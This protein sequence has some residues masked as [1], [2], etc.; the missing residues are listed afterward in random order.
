MLTKNA[1][2]GHGLKKITNKELLE[3]LLFLTENS[4][5]STKQEYKEERK[6]QKFPEE[7]F[8]E[9]RQDKKGNRWGKISLQ[10]FLNFIWKDKYS[11]SHEFSY[12]NR[13][14]RILHIE[15]PYTDMMDS[16][17]YFKGKNFLAWCESLYEKFWTNPN[18]ISSKL[19]FKRKIGYLEGSYSNSNKVRVYKEHKGILHIKLNK[20]EKQLHKSTQ[21]SHL[22]NITPHPIEVMPSF[23]DKIIR[24]PKAFLKNLSS[25]ISIEEHIKKQK[26]LKE[27]IDI[28]LKIVKEDKN[29]YILDEKARKNFSINLPRGHCRAAVVA[30]ELFFSKVKI[31]RH[32]NQPRIS[33][34]RD[35]FSNTNNYSTYN[36]RGI[37]IIDNNGNRTKIEYPFCMVTRLEIAQAYYPNMHYSDLSK[38]QKDKALSHFKEVTKKEYYCTSGKFIYKT[39]LY[40]LDNIV[41]NDT[42][43]YQLSPAPLFFEG[44]LEHGNFQ[45][46]ELNIIGKIENS[47]KKVLNKKRIGHTLSNLSLT[48]LCFVLIN[49]NHP[50]WINGEWHRLSL[51]SMK[52]NGW[53]QD[54]LVKNR[55][56]SKIIEMLENIFKALKSIGYIERY[57]FQK[58]NYKGLNGTFFWVN[59]P[60]LKKTGVAQSLPTEI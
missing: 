45:L 60:L 23:Q 42:K 28:K 25:V 55:K 12:L 5:T 20:K 59:Q 49:R 8:K 46:V 29:R 18:K 11:Q 33:E 41:N 24:Y 51:Q 16:N 36:L 9:I 43:V 2:N 40:Y 31:D 37:G 32:I 26:I 6:T 38:T 50:L 1:T 58:S 54:S 21:L 19:N 7:I 57:H 47:L 10:D 34:Y 56:W 48:I 13:A 35:M 17:S 3:S 14:A 52:Q 15:Q 4:N 53:F 27:D 30:M 22:N 39:P 44:I